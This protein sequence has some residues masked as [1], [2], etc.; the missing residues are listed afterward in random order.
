MRRRMAEDAPRTVSGRN[1]RPAKDRHHARTSSGSGRDALLCETAGRR[2]PRGSPEAPGK[3]EKAPDN[4]AFGFKTGHFSH[5]MTASAKWQ[6][7]SEPS[8][9][10]TSRAVTIM[11]P[12]TGG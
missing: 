8:G 4:G 10:T 11:F 5:S 2:A 3:R 12:H 6:A 1:L 7:L 9:F